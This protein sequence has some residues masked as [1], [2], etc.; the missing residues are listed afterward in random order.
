[1]KKFRS[2][3]RRFDPDEMVTRFV[4][5]KDAPHVSYLAAAFRTLLRP[6]QI[7]VGVEKL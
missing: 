3:T 4:L 6:Q 1:M 7:A 5:N 2:N